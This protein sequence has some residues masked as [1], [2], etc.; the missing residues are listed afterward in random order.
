MGAR[1]QFSKRSTIAGGYYCV[2]V[3]LYIIILAG[4]SDSDE[5]DVLAYEQIVY[6][7]SAPV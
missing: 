3:A 6:T 4:C 2:C 5:F 7:V 1:E